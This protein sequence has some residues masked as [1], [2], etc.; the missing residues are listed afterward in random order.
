[1]D[2]D[3][4]VGQSKMSFESEAFD[5]IYNTL[6]LS[7]CQIRIGRVV[8][9]RALCSGVGIN[10]ENSERGQYGGID[11]NVRLL[12][13]DEPDGEIKNGTVIEILQNGK[14]EKKGWIKART[15]GR[16]T[17]GGLTRLM[18]EAEHE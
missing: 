11:A 13:A 16:Y 17:I 8:I 14:D 5:A 12:S 9:A 18:L 10:R 2:G 6:V 4:Q 7:R 3:N 15:G 1:M